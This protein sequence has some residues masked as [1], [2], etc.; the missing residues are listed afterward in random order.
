M[1]DSFEGVGPGLRDEEVP[2]QA[3][4]SRCASPPEPLAPPRA[5]FRECLAPLR[6]PRGAL[7]RPEDQASAAPGCHGQTAGATHPSGDLSSP[8]C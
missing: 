3:P 7:D 2:G 8:A 5:G 6:G 1:M 4:A